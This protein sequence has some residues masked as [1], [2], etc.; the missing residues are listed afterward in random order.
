MYLMLSVRM[1]IRLRL[2]F[3]AARD[4][5]LRLKQPFPSSLKTN[6]QAN[7][8]L[9]AVLAVQAVIRKTASVPC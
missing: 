3:S 4:V 7:R 8:L 6:A 2:C 9:R 1:A 5:A